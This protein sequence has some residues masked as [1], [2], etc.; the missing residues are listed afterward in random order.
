M[1]RRPC[2]SVDQV[3]A[4]LDDTIEECD[5]YGEAAEYEFDADEP[6]MEGSDE[7]FGE[8]DDELRDQIEVDEME[9][10]TVVDECVVHVNIDEDGGNLGLVEG[11]EDMV[12]EE[13]EVEQEERSRALPT[14]WSEELT[15]VYIPPFSS[16][17]G[18]TLP[19]PDAA[20]AIFDLYF[21]PE[22][23]QEIVLESNRYAS[24]VLGESFNRYRQLKV[25]E[26]R[27]YFGFCMLMA[28]NRLPAVEDYW[29]RDPVYNY[30]PI[31]SRISRDRFRE[32]GR[33]LHFVDN[34]T[35]EPHG[36]PAYDRLGKIRPLIKHLSSRFRDVYSP[37]RDVAVDEAMIKFQGHSS[38]MQYMPMK[39]TKRGIK[40]WVLADSHNGYFWRFEV[41]TGKQGDTVE[42]GLPA[43]V[44]KSLT[45]ELKG[46]NYHVYFDNFFNSFELLNDLAS[47]NIFACGTA[48]SNRRGFPEALKKKTF[49][50]R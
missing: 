5:G 42:R 48:R 32:I 41:Y 31:A 39:P 26:L 35:L 6:M 3:V 1:A 14:E 47:D 4:A 20:L 22:I 44:V 21:T 12:E 25:D 9:D 30:S 49:P 24:Q 50:N 16:P 18:P 2:L 28:V 23:L 46:Q 40:V 19:I 38:L 43:R 36:H 11:S 27:A 13:G 45:E 37:H 8:F 17:F 10:E 34:A 15:P 7:E 29:K 33:Y